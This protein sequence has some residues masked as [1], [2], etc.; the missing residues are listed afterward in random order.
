MTNFVKHLYDGA[1]DQPVVSVAR[2]LNATAIQMLVAGGFAAIGF[3]LFLMEPNH[4]L[5]LFYWFAGIVFGGHFSDKVYDLI[6]NT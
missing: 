2:A 4:G 1:K 3:A 6:R 5:G